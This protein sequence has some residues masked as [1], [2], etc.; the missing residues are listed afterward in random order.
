MADGIAIV[1]TAG[2]A[3]AAVAYWVSFV[4]QNQGAGRTASILLYAALA[5][6]TAW[7]VVSHIELGYLPFVDAAHALSFV[8]WGIAVS[9]ATIEWRLGRTG[10]GAFVTPIAFL[11]QVVAAVFLVLQPVPGQLT[12][13]LR[14]L[15]F[16]IHIGS[17]LFSYCAFALAFAAGL[18]YI[19]LCSELR[20]KKLG[21]FFTR[22][23][24]LD[25]L[26]RMNYHAVALG[27][28][29]LTIGIGSGIVWSIEANRSGVWLQSKEISAIAVWLLYAAS[30]HTRWR[31]GW[32]GQRMAVFSVVNFILLLAVFFVTSFVMGS[33]QFGMG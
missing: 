30:L 20:L 17:A 3:A 24:P 26:G 32:R 13:I 25:V 31:M 12:E 16:E 4:R 2:Y 1:A 23:P 18:M 5:V 10:F 8:A 29:F 21:F 7:L 11:L 22:M 6:H 9:Y 15:W 28:L 19:L 27:F 14:S 33:H